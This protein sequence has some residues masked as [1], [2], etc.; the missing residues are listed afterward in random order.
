MSS[1][2]SFIIMN[3]KKLINHTLSCEPYS[4]EYKQ[5]W[6]SIFIY[7]TDLAKSRGLDYRDALIIKSIVDDL[8]F[9]NEVYIKHADPMDD[10]HAGDCSCMQALR[11]QQKEYLDEIRDDYISA[12]R[13]ANNRTLTFKHRKGYLIIARRL[14]NLWREENNTNLSSVPV[15]DLE[16]FGSD[17]NFI[18]QVGSVED[19]SDTEQ[20]IIRREYRDSIHQEPECDPNDSHYVGDTT[21]RNVGKP[22]GN[23][24]LLNGLYE[25][26][27]PEPSYM[28][29]Q[30]RRCMIRQLQ[31]SDNPD[32]I[33]MLYAL[34]PL[35]KRPS[36]SK[37][38][39]GIRLR[40]RREVM[41][42]R[43]DKLS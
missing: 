19:L 15:E 32:D 3:I 24:G 12:L 22:Y 34:I 8:V 5:G 2:C 13:Q 39:Y 1:N 11:E 14:R 17:A 38:D 18:P 4:Q 31:S 43:I 42:S 26:T 7:A 30:N 21:R 28:T 9:S 20:L 27:S 10:A 37:K 25:Q 41:N 6:R 35:S 16:Q 23:I 36:E 29:A 40:K 33:R